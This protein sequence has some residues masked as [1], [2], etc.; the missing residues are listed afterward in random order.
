MQRLSQC[1]IHR[2]SERFLRE[3]AAAEGLDNV[4]HQV[5]DVN[6]LQV[7]GP[8]DAI[9][10]VEMLEHVRNHPA[11]LTRLA[12]VAVPDAPLFIHVFA[13]VNDFWEFEDRG[14]GDWMSRYFFSGGIMPSHHEIGRILSP[15]EV[16]ESWWISGTNYERTLNAWLDNMDAQLAEATAILR[17]VYGPSTKTWI[18]RWRMFFMA[19]A[20]FFGFNAGKTLGV[21]HHLLHLG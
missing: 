20:E 3:R 5:I 6:D 21:S 13:H 11:L 9:V 10:T 18:Q 4:R 2:H 12:E 19:S 1:P 17:P 14:P 8:F 15:F 7:K 16:T